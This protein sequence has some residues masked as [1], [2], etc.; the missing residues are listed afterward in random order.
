M[1]LGK[2]Y[3]NILRGYIGDGASGYNRR[4]EGDIP[5]CVNVLSYITLLS[6]VSDYTLSDKVLSDFTLYKNLA[7]RLDTKELIDIEDVSTVEKK[8]YY[9]DYKLNPDNLI[10]APISND[11]VVIQPTYLECFF[12]NGYN[13]GL[14]RFLDVT[15]F[16]QTGDPNLTYSVQVE[17]ENGPQMQQYKIPMEYFM[18][19]NGILDIKLGGSPFLIYYTNHMPYD[20]MINWA[21]NQSTGHFADEK[22]RDAFVDMIRT[23]MDN[24]GR[25]SDFD[26][27]MKAAGQMTDGTKLLIKVLIVVLVIAVAAVVFI[28]VRKKLKEDAIS[29]TGVGQTN[30]GLLFDNDDDDDDDDGGF[31][32]K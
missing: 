22:E 4:V 20:L 2:D 16:V 30:T 21:Y 5:G 28:I 10:I 31:E 9:Q 27:Y 17:T 7:I 1:S 3:V 6:D 19:E 14:N 15:N 23:D 13:K 25:S 29:S 32:L 18:D 11:T 8:L 12:Y 26:A 24:L